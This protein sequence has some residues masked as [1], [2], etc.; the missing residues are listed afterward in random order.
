[1]RAARTRVDL[2][3]GVAATLAGLTTAY[4]AP[5][6]ALPRIDLALRAGNLLVPEATPVSFAWTVGLGHT[7]VM[8]G[9]LAA[10]YQR[11]LVERLPG[12]P[13]TRG[14]LWGLVAA[15]F[16]GLTVFPLLFGGGAFGIRWDQ[17]TPVT[18]MACGLVWGTTL[19]LFERR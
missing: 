8:G 17:A 1:M 12:G 5:M 11:W 18:L 9:F 3:A 16:A 15:T 2:R 6:L 7:L 4:W 13:A 19:G 10:I 14:A